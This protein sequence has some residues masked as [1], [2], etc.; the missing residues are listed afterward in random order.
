MAH[1]SNEDIRLAAQNDEAMTELAH[2][3]NL[4]I[5]RAASA[6]CRRFVT[7]HDDEY[8]IA[9]RAFCDAVQ[10]FDPE[11]DVSFETY[12]KLL[13][14]NR[15]IDYLRAESRHTGHLSLE[16][17]MENGRDFSD[18]SE[19]E[20]ENTQSAAAAEIARLSATIRVY[21]ISF[22]DLPDA[23]PKHQKTKELCAVAVTYMIRHP[24]IVEDMRRTHLL[25][26]KILQENCDIPRKTLE[27]HR[28]Y[29]M[30][31]TE[32]CL[33]DYPVITE[34]LRHMIKSAEDPGGS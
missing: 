30:T 32:V 18:S 9:L 17:E 19:V 4:F 21:G 22:T 2:K 8:A 16:D 10:K 34:Y 1:V 24:E 27:R 14:K 31:A 23:S 15:V 20:R 33:G 11:A 5:I 6:T 28:K 12:A 29:I 13:I 25:P 3:Y 26:M 7:K